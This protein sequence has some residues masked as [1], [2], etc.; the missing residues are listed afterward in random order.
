MTISRRLRRGQTD[1]NLTGVFDLIA[2]RKPTTDGAASADQGNLGAVFLSKNGDVLFQAL[3]A[4]IR[5]RTHHGGQ[6]AHPDDFTG[7]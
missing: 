1:R 2:R 3:F 6:L 5:L 7:D 4:Q